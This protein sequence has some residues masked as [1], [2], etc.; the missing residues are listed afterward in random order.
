M[1]KASKHLRHKWENVR[2]ALS[3]REA[4]DEQVIDLVAGLGNMPLSTAS[5]KV[6]EVV[7][8]VEKYATGVDV[9]VAEAK[10]PEKDTMVEQ[11][12]Y[13]KDN[14]YRALEGVKEAL[15]EHGIKRDDT[16]EKIRDIISYGDDDNSPE[17]NFEHYVNCAETHAAQVS[18][19]VIEANGA[20]NKA[21]AVVALAIQAVEEAP[22]EAERVRMA[23]RGGRL[24]SARRSV[25]EIFW[26]DGSLSLCSLSRSLSKY[27]SCLQIPPDRVVF[28]DT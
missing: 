24:Q 17:K 16:W 12:S 25:S 18:K 11:A 1:A 19:A 28:A 2:I 15:G 7:V 4:V 10:N 13:A 8:L 6:K 20:A 27:M 3:D 22:D 21:L 26:M 23:S 5:A 9:A 14:L